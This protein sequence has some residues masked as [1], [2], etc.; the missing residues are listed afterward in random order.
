M[1]LIIQVH[2]PAM[3]NVLSQCWFDEIKCADGLSALE[4]Y[5]SEYDEDK[6]KLSN[7]PVHDWACHAADAFRTF[8]VGYV[9][10]TT[11]GQ[12]L[13]NQNRPY[14]SKHEGFGW[15]L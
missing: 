13:K 5:R 9:D 6:K 10:K 2:I 15:M 3:R 11:Y 12:F 4:N 7:R 14:Q 8:A 1:D